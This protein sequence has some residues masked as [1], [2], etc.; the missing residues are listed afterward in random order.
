MAMIGSVVIVAKA[1]VATIPAIGLTL[2]PDIFHDAHSV[3]P[4]F[5]PGGN[6][7][8]NAKKAIRSA[9]ALQAEAEEINSKYVCPALPGPVTGRSGPRY[10]LA[11]TGCRFDLISE[12]D[13]SDEVLQGRK[14]SDR[15]ISLKTA[16]S[17]VTTK[18]VV[19]MHVA[20]IN[21]DIEPLLLQSTPAVL[22]VGTIWVLVAPLLTTHMVLAQ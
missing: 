7:R 6:I 13:I 8:A 12:A 21:E 16:N 2:K 1:S 22:S 14:P 9:A 5:R 15:P 4:L 18:E 10:W 19:P 20:S 11:D 17:G 3:N